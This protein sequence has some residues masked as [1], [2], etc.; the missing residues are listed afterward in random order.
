LH[1]GKGGGRRDGGGD[2]VKDHGLQRDTDAD[3]VDSE[4]GRYS[5]KGSQAWPALCEAEPGWRSRIELGA[6]QTGIGFRHAPR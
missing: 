6:V 5:K 3:I 4:A 1:R 2:Y